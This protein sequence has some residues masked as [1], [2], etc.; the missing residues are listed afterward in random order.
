MRPA[1]CLN[2]V[3][4]G[5]GIGRRGFLQC[6]LVTAGGLG[7]ADGLRSDTNA[8]DHA[9]L[10]SA[11]ETSVILLW[12]DGGAS[13]YET[14]DPKPDA[15]AEVRGELGSIDTSMPGVRFC[16]HLF[17]TAQL[18]DRLAI[19][20]SINHQDGLHEG[21]IHW[22]QSGYGFPRQFDP[23]NMRGPRHPAAATL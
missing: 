1:A 14:F 9:G 3:F 8:S 7:L 12:M 22:M 5:R 18:A 11:G 16:D 6:S 2:Q 10:R 20:R 13:H 17:R 21:G 15:P 19:V 4:A 23:V